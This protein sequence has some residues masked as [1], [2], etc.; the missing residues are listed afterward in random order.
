MSRQHFRLEPTIDREGY[1]IIDLDTANGT[2]VDGYRVEGRRPLNG[3]V[4]S[5]GSTL[6]VVDVPPDSDQLPSS[7][8]ADEASTRGI[9]G[10][11]AA[12]RALRRSIATVAP[13]DG[14]VLLLGP[15]GVGKDVTALAIHEASG[16]PG[17]FTPV[18]CAAIPPDLA[19][20]ELF[21]YVKGAFTGAEADRPGYFE[22]ASGGTLFLDE[23][24]DLSGHIQAK[25]LRVLE[26]GII[27]RVGSGEGRRVDLRIIAATH[28]D[29]ETS[30][31]RRDLL[32]RLTDWT[33]RI[34]RL[35]D[36]K[37]DV[38]ALW[39]RFFGME[40]HVPETTPEL[41]EALLLY[42]WPMNVREL[43]RLARRITQTASPGEP[44]D[45]DML[46]R[47]IRAPLQQ[48][49]EESDARRRAEEQARKIDDSNTPGYDV[50]VRALEEAGGNIKLAAKNNNWHRT[51][52]YR[53]INRLEIDKDRFRSK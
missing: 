5:A 22:R 27:H 30:G 52:L 43:K 24:G 36:R 21:G 34:P 26:D 2:F 4:V 9:F 45:I 14:A 20:A 39:D 7:P 11:S 1:D 29:L 42:D 8:T 19:E 17:P 23:V 50:I 31:F 33:L 15:T 48:R 3:R 13:T 28:I 53:W 6:F 47:D 44:V 40:G 37:A 25:L 16:R 41:R 35:A 12:T 46:P 38:L 10:I 49:L 32:A 18:N 51:Q